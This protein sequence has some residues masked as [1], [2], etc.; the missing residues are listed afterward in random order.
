MVPKA[1]FRTQLWAVEDWSASKVWVKLAKSWKRPNL[2]ESR[3]A[4]WRRS[5]RSYTGARGEKI[6][7]N[8][9]SMMDSGKRH[10]RQWE[11][12]SWRNFKLNKICQKC[13]TSCL[14][15]SVCG[16]CTWSTVESWWLSSS[17]T[18][19]IQ[20]QHGWHPA[21]ML[22]MLLGTAINFFFSR[23]PF[24]ITQYITSIPLIHDCSVVADMCCVTLRDG[25]KS[26]FKKRMVGRRKCIISALPTLWNTKYKC[27]SRCE[28]K[29]QVFSSLLPLWFPPAEVPFSFTKM[30]LFKGSTAPHVSF[31]E[32][33]RRRLLRFVSKESNLKLSEH[34][35]TLSTLI[36]RCRGDEWRN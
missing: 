18:R 2:Y 10:P 11:R 33:L 1:V 7:Q 35:K 13:S 34:P 15:S 19:E 16:F 14:T 5:R 9:T 26:H 31:R 24:W 21:N 6:C 12:K 23:F 29:R 27:K 32:P 3:S 17:I 36:R 20:R 30:E 4:G 22:Q 28:K 8:Q 25:G